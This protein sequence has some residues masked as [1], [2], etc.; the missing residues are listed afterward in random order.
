MKY[1][2]L[3]TGT[4]GKS[5]FKD[6]EAEIKDAGS[7]GQRSE[8]MKATGM[9]FSISGADYSL[10]FH[11]APRRQFVITLDGEVEITA[12][13]GEKRLLRHGDV[14]LADDTTGRGHISRAVNNRPWTA[15]FVTL[16]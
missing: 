6:V 10:D 15:I 12:S 4:D 3:Y 7:R 5:H 16:D 14:M 8:L 11:P 1:V 9:L 13:D 2:H